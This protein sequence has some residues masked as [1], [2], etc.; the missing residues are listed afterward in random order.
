MIKL[1]ARTNEGKKTI[2][3]PER[4]DEVTV[5]QFQR[6]YSEWKNEDIIQAFSILSG[7]QYN[8]I[9]E[10]KDGNLEK[11]MYSSIRFLFETPMPFDQSHMPMFLDFTVNG[12]A[13]PIM[14]PKHLGRLSIGQAIQ[15]RK[16]VEGVN[17]LRSAIS[18]VTAIYVQ[19]ILDESKFDHLRAIEIEQ[20]ILRM[21]A[22][23]IYPI[24]F[25]L[26]KRLYG[27]GNWWTNIFSRIKH[28]IANAGI[29]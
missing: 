1:K 2:L 10:S 7:E 13:K 6:L 5:E 24:G 9:A 29:I 11:V 17:D 14:M 23:K 8:T 22:S 26:F 18:I 27:S 21:P 15:A 19:P 20:Q 12:K 3:V 28:L 25:F 16:S 4:W